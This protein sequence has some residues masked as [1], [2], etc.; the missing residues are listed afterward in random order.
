MYELEPQGFKALK[1]VSKDR[2]PKIHN[3][4]AVSKGCKRPGFFI[5][6]NDRTVFSQMVNIYDPIQ[7]KNSIGY[8]NSSGTLLPSPQNVPHRTR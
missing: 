5:H 7:A 3:Y 6:L 8:Q 2:T 4:V 1:H